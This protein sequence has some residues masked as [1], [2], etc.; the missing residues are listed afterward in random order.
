MQ[1]VSVDVWMSNYTRSI[2]QPSLRISLNHFFCMSHFLI[3]VIYSRAVNTTDRRLHLDRTFAVPVWT[4]IGL[5]PSG[6]HLSL[7]SFYHIMSEPD[8]TLELPEVFYLPMDTTWLCLLD[9]WVGLR[10]CPPRQTE[11][12][13][14]SS[15]RNAFLMSDCRLNKHRRGFYQEFFIYVFI[16]LQKSFKV[17]VVWSGTELFNQQ[18]GTLPFIFLDFKLWFPH[19]FTQ[20]TRNFLKDGAVWVYFHGIWFIFDRY[21]GIPPLFQSQ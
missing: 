8:L 19:I 21:A 5:S 6:I 3:D 17:V 12:R 13:K 2:K 9:A 7:W 18:M 10:Q 20:V 14:M 15:T 11:G 1:W 16:F 4:H